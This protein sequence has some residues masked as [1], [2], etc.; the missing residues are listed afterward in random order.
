MPECTRRLTLQVCAA[1]KAAFPLDVCGRSLLAPAS[2]T[3]AVKL[4]DAKPLICNLQHAVSA[5]RALALIAG[6]VAT[7]R[8]A[9]DTGGGYR[10]IAASA[11]LMASSHSA[12]ECAPAQAAFI[13]ETA[14][15]SVAASNAEASARR[16]SPHP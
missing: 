2:A 3:S 4:P 1:K 10:L 8:R 13:N 11:A 15:R 12:R 9:V 5:L 14:S 16:N 6:R 7:N